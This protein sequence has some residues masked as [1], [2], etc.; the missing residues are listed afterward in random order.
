M[1]IVWSNGG[2]G[3]RRV[4][5]ACRLTPVTGA[6]N[7]GHFADPEWIV[8]LDFHHACCDGQGAR[9]FLSEWFSKYHAEVEGLECKLTSL[10]PARLAE[11]GTYSQVGPGVGFWEGMRNLLLTIWGQTARISQGDDAEEGRTWLEQ[12]VL[13]AEQTRQVRIFFQATRFTMNDVGLAASMLA[14][15]DVFPDQS[16]G[17]LVTIMNPIDLRRPSNSRLPT[18]NRLGF[19]FIRRRLPTSLAVSKLLDSI[20]GELNYIKQRRVGEEF[21]KGMLAVRGIPGAMKKIDDWGWFTPTLLFTCLGDTTRMFDSGIQRIRER[22]LWAGCGCNTFPDIHPWG[23]GLRWAS[24]R[25]KR[26]ID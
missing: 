12:R 17:R 19:V 7:A 21:E 18:C 15:R 16:R 24:L 6:A 22:S 2:R 8:V 9:Q 23:T 5:P 3:E 11:R 10:R 14:F 25:A 4:S 1:G 13:N 20:D 26:M